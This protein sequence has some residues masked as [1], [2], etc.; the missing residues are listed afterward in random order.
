MI[1][2]PEQWDYGNSWAPMNSFVIEGLFETGQK[3]AME[4][5]LNLAKIWVKTNYLGFKATGHMFEKV[6][7]FTKGVQI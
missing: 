3:D 6:S 5:A 4:V 7:T 2:S 1:L